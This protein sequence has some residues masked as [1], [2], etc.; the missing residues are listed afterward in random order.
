MS[1]KV[2][3]LKLGFYQS[4]KGKLL[5]SGTPP[6]FDS[7]K[8]RVNSTKSTI[9]TFSLLTSKK[10]FS[11]SKSPENVSE[12]VT[13]NKMQD[14]MLNLK[15]NFTSRVRKASVKNTEIYAEKFLTP[16]SNCKNYFKEEPE[17]INTPSFH[18]QK[19]KKIHELRAM[20]EKLIVEQEKMKEQISSQNSLLEK[21]S[22]PKFP[23]K[24]QAFHEEIEGI[25]RCRSIVKR[26]LP[27]ENE[28]KRDS[29]S[30]KHIVAKGF[31]CTSLNTSEKNSPR[32]G[33]DE[34]SS[35]PFMFGKKGDTMVSA[36][37]SKM[38]Y[39]KDTPKLIRNSRFPKDIF[40]V[41]K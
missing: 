6:L 37:L 14:T 31:K 39:Y 9:K 20:C 34:E 26:R 4:P 12:L 18:K 13:T 10:R 16:N 11:L 8:N 24:V 41:K 17:R 21:L 25:Q 32:G 7:D 28:R 3:Y 29:I 2:S 38:K 36:G 33:N 23:M 35:L 5:A 27:R 22:F 40:I 30:L 1:G 15:D 19:D